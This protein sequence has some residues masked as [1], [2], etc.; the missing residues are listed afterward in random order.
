[1]VVGRKRP[2]GASKKVKF[3]HISH[4]KKLFAFFF[5]LSVLSGA[6]SDTPFSPEILVIQIDRN[7]KYR[8]MGK[9]KKEITPQKRLNHKPELRDTRNLPQL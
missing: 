6:S 5:P 1:M 9:R 2:S 8:K 4:V 3:P 7:R